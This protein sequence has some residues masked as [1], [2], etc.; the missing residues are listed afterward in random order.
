[1]EVMRCL[2]ASFL[3]WTVPVLGD[4]DFEGA[5]PESPILPP[6]NAVD[7]ILPKTIQKA[8]QELGLN[9]GGVPVFHDKRNILE[10][11]FYGDR[12][13]VPYSQ[14]TSILIGKDLKKYWLANRFSHPAPTTILGP[15]QGNALDDLKVRNLLEEGL[16]NGNYST[17]MQAVSGLLKSEAYD[18][19][20]LGL[21]LI[22]TAMKQSPREVDSFVHFLERSFPS[23]E[24]AFGKM[25]LSAETK[26]ALQSMKNARN[27]I[28]EVTVQPPARI[29]QSGYDPVKEQRNGVGVLPDEFWGESRNGLQAAITIPANLKPSVHSNL[30]SLLRISSH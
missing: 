22:P 12:C 7:V 9:M 10:L 28:K 4:S 6:K 16:K 11:S 27:R 14:G 25:G 30:H 18:L 24:E 13:G 17:Y 20:Q 23:Q 15:F 26:L 5:S 29:Y 1:M 2:F 3:L 19:T 21:Q 8:A